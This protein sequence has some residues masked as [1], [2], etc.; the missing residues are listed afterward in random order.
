M[1][2]FAYPTR[3]ATMLIRTIAELDPGAGGADLTAILVKDRIPHPYV[4][5]AGG[6]R[7]L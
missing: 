1:N 4:W 2:A 6:S 7:S 3:S 5:W